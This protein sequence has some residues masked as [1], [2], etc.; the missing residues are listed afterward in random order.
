MIRIN[1]LPKEAQGSASSLL[2]L[3]LPWKLISRAVIGGVVIGSVGLL[4]TNQIHARTLVMLTAEWNHLQPERA[5]LEQNQ[6]ALKALQNR[7]SILK[8]LKEPEA[9]WAPRLNLLSD[10]LVSQLWLIYLEFDLTN[11]SSTKP[12]TAAGSPAVPPKNPAAKTSSKTATLLTLKGSAFVTDTGSGAP[13]NRYLQRLKEQPEFRRW[14]RNV[15]L[16]S[17]EQRQ[18]HQEQVSDFEILLTPEGL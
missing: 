2:V 10:A 7:T 15:E 9:Q 6:E 11:D 16:K 8:A 14:F 18:I 4:V 13:V 3:G 17:V 5:K 1:L 12:A